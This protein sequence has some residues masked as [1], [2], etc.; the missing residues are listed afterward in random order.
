V[1]VAGAPRVIQRVGV[2]R[3]GQAVLANHCDF[4][5]PPPHGGLR[6]VNAAGTL[7]A[8]S[9]QPLPLGRQGRRQAEGEF[10]VGLL[11]QVTTPASNF[12]GRRLDGLQP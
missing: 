12:P 1:D 11:L 3:Q 5:F 10:L 7:P 8:V 6:P 2:R 9:V 4:Q